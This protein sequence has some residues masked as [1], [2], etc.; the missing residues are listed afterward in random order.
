MQWFAHKNKPAAIPEVTEDGSDPRRGAQ[1]H[2]NATLN[3]ELGEVVDVSSSGVRLRCQSK[4]PFAPGAFTSISFTYS[5]GK[6]QIQVQ[7]RWRKRF[8]LRGGHEVGLMFVK[9][10]PNVI[11]AI[12]SLVKFG[13]FCPDAIDEN[14]TREQPKSKPKSKKNL[15]VSVNL[16]DHYAVLGLTDDADEDAIHS[17]YR[18]L[19]RQYHPD[20]SEAPDAQDR[21]I[22]VCQAYKVL[23]D[24]Q[25]RKT[26]DLRRAG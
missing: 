23:S 10:S 22:G 6:L 21:F 12:E 3:C 1:R 5:G 17:A 8:G 20:T 16:P 13:F 26:Y 24:T 18:K 2:A 4:P 14:D 15:N 25:M 19:A 9:A 11:K 7:E